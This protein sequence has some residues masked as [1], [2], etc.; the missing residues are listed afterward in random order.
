MKAVVATTDTCNAATASRREA[1]IALPGGKEMDCHRHMMNLYGCKAPSIAL[2]AHLRLLMKDSLDEIDPSLRIDTPHLHL[3]RAF[4]KNFSLSCNYVKGDGEDFLMFVRTK[5]PGVYLYPVESTHGSRMDIL[6]TSAPAIYMNRVPCLIFLKFVCRDGGGNVLQ[7][8]LLCLL[9]CQEMVAQ[10]RL[11]CIL[12]MSCLLPLRWFAGKSHELTPPTYKWGAVCMS[13]VMI[14]YHKALKHLQANPGLIVSDVHMMSIFSEL[15]YELPPFKEYLD[16]TFRGQRTV[17]HRGSGARLMGM[18]KLREESFYPTNEANQEAEALV[19]E[20]GKVAVNAIIKDME[21]RK[22]NAWKYLEGSGLPFSYDTLLKQ[23][24]SADA[25][26]VEDLLPGIKCSND[27]AESLLGTTTGVIQKGNMIGLSNAG[28]VGSVTRQQLFSREHDNAGK[29]ARSGKKKKK[30]KS[31]ALFHNKSAAMQESLIKFGIAEAPAQRLRNAADQQMHAMKKLEKV[32]AELKQS[33]AKAQKALDE[34]VRYYSMYSNCIKGDPESVDKMMD[35][36]RLKKEKKRILVDNIKCRVVGLGWTQFK[37]TMSVNGKQRPLEEL[38]E[39]LKTI[40]E[41]EKDLDV[42]PQ[43]NLV[44][45]KNKKS[46]PILGTFNADR[47]ELEAKELAEQ[48][49][50]VKKAIERERKAR[51]ENNSVYGRLQDWFPPTIDQL[52]ENKTRI[53]VYWEFHDEDTGVT[54]YAWCQGKVD[55]KVEGEDHT[56][57]V[58]WDPTPD[59]NGWEEELVDNVELLPELWNKQCPMG[60]RKDID[61][62][63]S[64]NYYD[65]NDLLI[66]NDEVF[67]DENNEEEQSDDE[68]DDEKS[69]SSDGDDSDSDNE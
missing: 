15:E 1:L 46:E 32:E 38:A 54:D 6:Y 63:L 62:E 59:S 3:A 8:N 37:I 36:T 12:Y 5:L 31:F 33:A 24:G 21:D 48:K 28:A 20:L 61:V 27:V 29:K 58:L 45:N 39:H 40:I 52:V 19:I 16:L 25:I 67:N 34:Q 13:R 17:V 60:W 49:E 14:I 50:M 4:Y 23:Y 64:E 42:P 69:D 55:G 57:E 30:R 10:T 65:A 35:E 11:L 26:P 7:R 47:R 44:L 51:G 2:A 66:D 22:K 56:V 41:E 43:P 18:Q 68:D 9:S 53:D